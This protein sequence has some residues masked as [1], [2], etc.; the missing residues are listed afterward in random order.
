MNTLLQSM[1]MF[2]DVMFLFFFFL[3]VM[4]LIGL[5]LFLG[6]LRNKCVWNTAEAKSREYATNSSKFQS[7]FL[8]SE[9][10]NNVLGIIYGV[11]MDMFNVA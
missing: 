1:K 8:L 11:I 6:V 7:K 2:S 10:I 9:Q 5:Q 4:A 3:C